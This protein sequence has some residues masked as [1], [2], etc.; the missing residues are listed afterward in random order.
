M[1]IIGTLPYTLVDG[2]TADAVQVM[3][4]YDYIQAQVNENALPLAGGEMTGDITSTA[5]ASFAGQLIGGGTD[6]NDSA[7]GGVIGEY[8][9]VTNPA[10]G[11]VA[12]VANTP[13]NIVALTLAAG[14]WDVMANWVVAPSGGAQ[15]THIIAAIS[16]VSA[17]L[18]TPSDGGYTDLGLNF[19]ANQLQA[20]PIGPVRVSLAAPANVYLVAA[21]SFG[22]GAVGGYGFI[23]ARRA[24]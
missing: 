3:A 18:P 14:D 1:A 9:F 13:A 7:A 22:V 5:G 8:V 23:G 19:S 15:S 17:S 12:L 24:R 21:V 2:S 6:T 16:L 11:A 10:S 4:N 20:G